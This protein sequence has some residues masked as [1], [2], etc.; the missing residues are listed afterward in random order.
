MH[1]VRTIWSYIYNMH[2]GNDTKR[3]L[4]RSH[5]C[6]TGHIYIYICPFWRPVVQLFGLK[7][8]TLLSH[9][10]KEKVAISFS[11][12]HPFS[13]PCTTAAMI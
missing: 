11:P 8:S 6:S 13:P 9:R 2:E 1:V 5:N 7:W 4:D 3:N 12:L 10:A